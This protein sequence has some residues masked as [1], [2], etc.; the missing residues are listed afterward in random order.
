MTTPPLP[1]DLTYAAIFGN[2]PGSEVA[3]TLSRLERYIGPTLTPATALMLCITLR[4]IDL[5]LSLILAS[6]R[7]LHDARLMFATSMTEVRSSE[8]LTIALQNETIRRLHEENRVLRNAV[9]TRI[10]ARSEPRL[11]AFTLVML[12]VIA[13]GSCWVGLLR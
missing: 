9:S 12:V 10:S 2:P 1:L 8:A 11:I 3:A 6:E 4:P 13:A 5:Y 7:Q